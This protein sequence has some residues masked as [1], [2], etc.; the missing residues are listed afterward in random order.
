MELSVTLSWQ[1]TSLES[2]EVGA[3]P[4]VRHFLQRLQLPQLFDQH[5]PVLPGRQ[6][7]LSSART[8][9]LLVTNLLLARQPLYALAGW[10]S[11]RVPE[12]LDLQPGQAHLLNDDRWGRAL[13]HLRRADRASM[14]TALVLHAVRTFNID[15]SEFHQDT[16][17]VTFSGD[18]S[19]QPPVGHTN[20][21]PRIAFGYNKDHRPDL[22]QLLYSITITA[23]G[24]VPIHCKT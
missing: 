16:T 11:R 19:S 9:S 13:D 22:K 15:M 5:L 20:R 6:P 23:D 2:L 8:L 24:A 17:T 7:T 14:L 3:T 21:P 4:L 1:Q 12:H 18:Y 10:I